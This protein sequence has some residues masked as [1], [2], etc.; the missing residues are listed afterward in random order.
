MLLAY[1]ARTQKL[2]SDIL[3]HLAPP[4]SKGGCHDHS[5]A[6]RTLL[7]LQRTQS[8]H[9]NDWCR[10]YFRTFWSKELHLLWL[11]C[12]LALPILLN[13]RSGYEL[14]GGGGGEVNDSTDGD[15]TGMHSRKVSFLT[16]ILGI[17]AL[18]P[19]VIQCPD[20]MEQVT[21]LMESEQ[22][23]ANYTA[24]I[25]QQIYLWHRMLKACR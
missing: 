3:W 6:R 18:P 25:S 13:F 8:S 14:V 12:F 20:G 16:Y 17:S 19:T 21:E 7:D 11:A 1:S 22:S 24:K 5:V 10:K 4:Q 23:R 15:W 9:T 2:R